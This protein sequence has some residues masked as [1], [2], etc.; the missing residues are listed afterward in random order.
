MLKKCNFESTISYGEY[1]FLTSMTHFWRSCPINFLNEFFKKFFFTWFST[2]EIVLKKIST[3]K[4]R[5][6]I[7][8]SMPLWD[9][10][11]NETELNPWYPTLS[12]T[13]FEKKYIDF[14]NM[15]IPPLKTKWRYYYWMWNIQMYHVSPF[16]LSVTVLY[17]TKKHP[18]SENY[19]FHFFPFF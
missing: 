18:T 9:H 12:S 14:E 17:I 13:D 4:F 7:I 10:E 15:L 1:N 11:S 16:W 5:K 3:E 8:S 6:K 19:F 2:L